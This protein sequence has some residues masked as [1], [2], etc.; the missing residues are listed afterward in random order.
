MNKKLDP[1]VVTEYQPGV[2]AAQARIGHEVAR[3][4]IW[5]YAYDE[6][7]LLEIH[8]RP[9]FDP[10]TRHYGFLG[11]GMVGYMFSNISPSKDGKTLEAWI[12]FP[13]VL[14][15]HEQ[16]AERLVGR[17]LRMLKA[18]GVARVEGRVTTMC[19]G[20]IALA[21][22]MGFA[23]R[24][25]GYKVYYSYE[26]SQGKLDQLDGSA[27]EINLQKDLDNCAH[28]ATRWYQ[29][30]PDW[31]RARLIMHHQLEIITHAGIWDGSDLIASCLTAPNLI[32]PSTAANFYIYTPDEHA[33][34]LLLVNAV[35]KCVDHGVNNLIADLID[36]HHWFETVYQELGFKK[37][38]KW[39]RCEKA[40]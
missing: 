12:D 6:E 3:N 31:C 27:R 25:W 4:W 33:L 9:D 23:I 37:V 38:A 17:A 15:G 11:D 8:T 21:E 5:P 18:K 26:M 40:L 36:N 30:P 19:P 22:K 35:N 29:Q 13:R 32:R 16:I 39:V 10:D 24:D 1:Y 20:D 7:D 34:K 14:P 28:L 2:E